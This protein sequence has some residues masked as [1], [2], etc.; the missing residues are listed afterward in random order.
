MVDDCSCACSKAR[1]INL[2]QDSP[3]YLWF[4]FARRSTP[5]RVESSCRILENGS[6]ACFSVLLLPSGLGPQSPIA[7]KHGKFN[8]RW[9]YVAIRLTRSSGAPVVRYIS[10]FTQFESQYSRSL[11]SGHNLCECGV[12]GTLKNK[13][14]KIGVLLEYYLGTQADF[15]LAIGQNGS[16]SVSLF[17]A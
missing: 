11:Q 9:L 8:R 10:T 4:L 17:R 6:R 16:R 5:G 1:F 3:P 13:Y 12:L 15:F 7:N 14:A 2:N